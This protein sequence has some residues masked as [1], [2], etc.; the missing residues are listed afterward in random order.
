MS[1]FLE[2]DLSPV[3]SSREY[4][5]TPEEPT[6]RILSAT[7]VAPWDI[8]NMGEVLGTTQGSSTSSAA[9]PRERIVLAHDYATQRGGAERVA[10]KIAEAFPGAPMF[11]TLY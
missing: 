1:T 4:W 7:R 11:T 9:L 8:S 2:G 6:S 5:S 3:S 10:L